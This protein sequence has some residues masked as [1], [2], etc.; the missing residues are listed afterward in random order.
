MAY[1]QIGK[2]TEHAYRSDSGRFQVDT[3]LDGQGND[4]TN[5]IDVG[6]PFQNDE[7]LKRYLSGIFNIPIA[8]IELGDL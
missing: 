7:E 4:V 5:R 6:L 1:F 8:E 3:V 2:D